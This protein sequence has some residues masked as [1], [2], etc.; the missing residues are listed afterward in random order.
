[1]SNIMADNH[2]YNIRI[3]T[4]EIKVIF[5]A[6]GSD[7]PLHKYDLRIMSSLLDEFKTITDSRIVSI[8]FDQRKILCHEIGEDLTWFVYRNVGFKYPDD[9]DMD[10]FDVCTSI[11]RKL[12]ISTEEDIDTEE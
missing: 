10:I 1:M 6:F 8:T 5:R 2:I 11:L 7:R 3:T 9:I 12:Y 4:D